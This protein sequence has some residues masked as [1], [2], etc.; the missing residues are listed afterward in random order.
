MTIEVY[1]QP[2]GADEPNHVG[3]VVPGEVMSISDFSNGSREIISAQCWPDD[4]GG[5]VYRFANSG[6]EEDTQTGQRLIPITEYT[7]DRREAVIGYGRSY[8]KNITRETRDVG[9]LILQHVGT[10]PRQ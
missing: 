2:E 7:L 3:T 4:R 9:R 8:E 1:I 10:R 5:D 6:F